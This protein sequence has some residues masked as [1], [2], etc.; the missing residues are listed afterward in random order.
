[1]LPHAR[2]HAASKLRCSLQLVPHSIQGLNVV[3][4]DFEELDLNIPY[5][6]GYLGFREVPAYST[7]LAR[8]KARCEGAHAS[9]HTAAPVATIHNPCDAATPA[10]TTCSHSGTAVWPQVVLVDGFGV[11]HHRRCSLCHFVLSLL[12]PPVT[13][14]LQT[15]QCSLG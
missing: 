7:L 10:M 2:Y 1:M 4:Q 9:S 3:Y 5:R 15:Q 8:L 14:H 6:S 11:L 12:T 13:W